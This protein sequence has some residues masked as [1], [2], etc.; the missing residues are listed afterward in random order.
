MRRTIA[1]SRRAA[2]A[3]ALALGAAAPEPRAAPDFDL[4]LAGGTVVDGT[5]APRRLADVAVSGDRIAAIGDLRGRTA[6]RTID[7]TGLVVAPGFI[8]M[9]G[10][11]E[12]TILVDP[13]GV[14]KVTQGVTTEITGE[15]VSVAPVNA[16]TLRGDSAQFAAWGLTVDWHDL[17]GYFD[18]LRRS[19]TPFNLATFVGA[20]QVRKYVLGDAARAPTA[21][22]LARM[23]ALVDTAM[24]QGALG[25]SS[26]LVY[27]PAFYARTAELIALARAAARYGGV[28]ATHI[29]NEGPRIDEALGEAFRIG[30]EARIPVE[31]WHLKVAGRA[32]WGRMPR[33]LARFEAL[34]AAGR[35]VGANS[36]PY[37]ASATG[38]DA[39]IPAWA[40]AGGDDAMLRR[41]REPATRARIER[42]MRGGTGQESFSR[43]AGGLSGVMVLGVLDTTLRRF[44]GR[45]ISDIA[46]EEGRDP[47]DVLFDLLIADHANTGAAYFS[48]SEADVA[49]T[50]AAPWVGVGMDFGAVAPDGPL[51]MRQVHPRAYGTFPRLLGRYVREQRLLS[52]ETAVHKMTAVPAERMGLRNRGVLRVGDFADITVFDPGTVA[53]RATFAEPH[54]V[55]VGIRYVLVNGQLTLD[56]GRLTGAR[57][58]RPLRGPGW[59][60]P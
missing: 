42:E 19:G 45:R 39:T 47:Y 35:R 28:Y 11:S 49:A 48:M 56:E 55:S 59:R 23:V 13:R 34:R 25:V 51:H 14:S 32:N 60:A 9:L 29:R 33:I 44:E 22:E 46:R 20:T 6:R 54:R 52:L 30:R 1:L 10:H 36:Y 50:I 5:G 12:I 57:P 43:S 38:L 2:V 26:A 53:D 27:A 3:A 37:T 4:L 17:D 58:G 31:V 15:G 24:R 18:R 8:D 41:L 21:V 16:N 40:H 7:A